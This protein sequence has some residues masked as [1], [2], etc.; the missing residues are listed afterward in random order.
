MLGR[1]KV[2]VVLADDHRVVTD[3]VKAMLAGEPEFEVVG[4]AD[5][6]R[7]VPAMIDELKPQVLVLDLSMPTLGGLEVLRQLKLRQ[8][9]LLVVILSMF[10]DAGHASAALRAGASAYV[11]KQAPTQ[12]LVKAMRAAMAGERYLSPPLSSDAIDNYEGAHAE[13]L[14]PYETLTAR[15]REILQLAAS[16]STNAAIALKLG[17][18]RRTV[19][20]HRA[21]LLRKLRLRSATELVR[22]AVRRGLI[23]AD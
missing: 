10:S 12:E 15:E 3:G 23:S 7:A 5:D 4:A 13:S 16:G 14:D 6:G 2:R 19:E 8:P 22:F 1:V 9:G 20:A 21:N 18:S 17:I 11:T